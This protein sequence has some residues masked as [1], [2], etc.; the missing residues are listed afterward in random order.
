MLMIFFSNNLNHAYSKNELLEQKHSL[1]QKITSIHTYDS[2]KI[3]DFSKI[4]LNSKYLSQGNP[5]ITV[6]PVSKA[7]CEKKVNGIHR[8]NNSQSQAIC[9]DKFMSPLPGG[10]AG[11]ESK[12]CIDQFEFPNI[13]CEYPVVW[14]RAKTSHEICQALGKRLCD[15]SE[16]ESACAGKRSRQEYIFGTTSQ[17]IFQIHK[18]QRTIINKHREK[19]WA[20]GTQQNHSLCAT[21][22]VKTEACNNALK[23]GKSVWNSCGSNTYP[24]GFFPECKSQVDVYDQHGNAAEHMNLPLLKH[25]FTRLESSGH[26]EMKGSWFIFKKYNAHPD[27]CFW[28]A[29]YW[30]GTKLSSKKSHHNYHLSFRCCKDI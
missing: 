30:H 24:S 4:Y 3:R 14:V 26:I 20:Y 19:I 15:A 9:K 1:I 12:V 7:T 28:R 21:D 10:Q 8:F 6:H 5:K 25:E 16:W 18:N 22:S 27:D 11:G 17:S 2:K 29:P 13:P 23:Q